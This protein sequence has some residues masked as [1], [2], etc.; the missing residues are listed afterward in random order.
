[1]KKYLLVGV[2]AGLVSGGAMADCAYSESETVTIVE[3][4]DFVK[5][6]YQVARP[7]K[8]YRPCMKKQNAVKPIRMKTHTEVVEHYQVLQPVTVYKPA[9][10][11]VRRYVVPAKR[12]AEC[13]M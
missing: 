3:T 9:G 8:E 6:N 1:M 12:C 10:T 2:V 4:V 13:A 5:T 7:V 11:E